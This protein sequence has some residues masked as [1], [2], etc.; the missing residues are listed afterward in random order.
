[1]KWN[2]KKILRALRI[3]GVLFSPKTLALQRKPVHWPDLGI[4]YI[5]LDD[6]VERRS[7]MDE[8]LKRLGLSRIRFPAVRPDPARLHRAFASYSDL[9]LV[10]WL[11]TP[12]KAEERI[13]L[14]GAYLSH[15]M[16]MDSIP[17]RDGFTLLLED[18]VFFRGRAFFHLLQRLLYREEGFPEF[19]LMLFDCVGNYEKADKVAPGLYRP[20]GGYPRYMGAHAVLIK[21]SSLDH[22]KKCLDDSPIE[23]IDNLYLDPSTGLRT[24]VFR[25][26][27]CTTA[28]V[29][30]NSSIRR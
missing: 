18:D 15:R 30:M 7:H 19:D 2:R 5:N 14:V 25:S 1:M 10:D 29:A 4:Y 13:G 6:A 23:N 16:V 27:L 24:F 28:R 3:A 8:H 21:N 12:R 11:H 9:E 26:F 20:K 22:I 17:R